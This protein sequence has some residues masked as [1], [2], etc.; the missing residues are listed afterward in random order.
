MSE[1]IWAALIEQARA[2]APCDDTLCHIDA[3]VGGA[4]TWLTHVSVFDHAC[5]VCPKGKLP[6]HLVSLDALQGTKREELAARVARWLTHAH[7]TDDR[8]ELGRDSVAVDGTA[9][10]AGGEGGRLAAADTSAA[11]AP[12]DVATAGDIA[13]PAGDASLDGSDRPISS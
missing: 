5:E 7:M 6:Q 4:Y 9:G 8:P 3:I 2:V 1:D 11:G 13:G 10:V 12:A